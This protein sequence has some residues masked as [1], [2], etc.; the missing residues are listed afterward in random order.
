[1]EFLNITKEGPKSMNFLMQNDSS[2][3]LKLCQPG[4][5]PHRDMEYEYHYRPC[6]FMVKNVQDTRSKITR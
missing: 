3:Y 6:F 4:Q 5:K 1:M 2:M